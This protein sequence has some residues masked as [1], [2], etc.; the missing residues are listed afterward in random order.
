M[1]EANKQKALEIAKKLSSIAPAL[2]SGLF[3][4]ELEGAKRNEL[5]LAIIHQKP[6][7]GGR[8]GP[9]FELESFL[10]DLEEIS[11]L[12]HTE[13]ELIELSAHGIVALFGGGNKEGT[14][15]T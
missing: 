1:S 10:K 4:M 3:L 7:G 6:E 12:L 14:D 9:T 11:K 13:D 2:K 5:K 8:V 15:Q